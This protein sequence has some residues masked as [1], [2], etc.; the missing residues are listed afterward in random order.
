MQPRIISTIAPARGASSAGMAGARLI[1]SSGAGRSG[2]GD[3]ALPGDWRSFELRGATQPLLHGRA[4]LR[5]DPSLACGPGGTGGNARRATP[6]PGLE[7]PMD[8]FERDEPVAR[9]RAALG[10]DPHDAA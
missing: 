4:P 3:A 8:P 9:L 6:R 5:V 10:G 2:R 1:G 7:G